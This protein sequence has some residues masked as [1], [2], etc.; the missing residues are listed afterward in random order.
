M[1]SLFKAAH[2][3]ELSPGPSVPEAEPLTTQPFGIA[4]R[5]WENGF[6]K[7]CPKYQSTRR[8]GV[9]DPTILA[10]LRFWRPAILAGR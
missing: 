9:S 6:A 10:H 1:L 2:G 7:V 8:Y 5:Y 3:H 4:I